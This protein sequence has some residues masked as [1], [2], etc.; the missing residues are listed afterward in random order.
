[1]GVGLHLDGLH[2]ST[3]TEVVIVFH[4]III[5]CDE[6]DILIELE[7]LLETLGEKLA[8]HIGHGQVLVG[9]LNW[10]EMILSH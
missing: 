2:K 1:M 7:E 10:S 3:R 4:R 8:R 9:E 5:F 6:G